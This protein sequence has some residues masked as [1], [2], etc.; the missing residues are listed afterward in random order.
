VFSARCRIVYTT[1]KE[2]AATEWY[3]DE[4]TTPVDN[5]AER[6]DCSGGF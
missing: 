4:E 3:A 5:A 6:D 2:V 1:A